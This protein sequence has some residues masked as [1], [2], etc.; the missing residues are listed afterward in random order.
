MLLCHLDELQLCRVLAVRDILPASKAGAHCGLTEASFSNG[1]LCLLL[2]DSMCCHL[3][4]SLQHAKQDGSH[5][6]V[7]ILSCFSGPHFAY[8]AT[9]PY[10]RAR[11]LESAL[12]PPDGSPNKIIQASDVR[13]GPGNQS[14][15]AAPMENGMHGLTIRAA[16]A[17]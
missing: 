13:I 17:G 11:R 14:D 2:M 10:E 1:G 16:L 5:K 3:L 4:P 6:R 7:R 15:K 9:F 12:N 8:P